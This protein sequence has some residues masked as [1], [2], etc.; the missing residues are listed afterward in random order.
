MQRL[1]SLA[2]RFGFDALIVVA[3]TESVIELIARHDAP[4]SPSSPTWFATAALLAL[5]LPLL[6]RRRFPFAV[7]TTVLIFATA[8]SFGDGRLMVFTNGAYA[9]GLAA[10]YLLGNQVSAGQAPIG[11]LVAA[12]GV[13]IVV[14]N[15][16]LHTAGELVVTPALYGIA[17]LAGFALRDRGARAVAAEERAARLEQQHELD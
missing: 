12:S 7:P 15:N 17:W 6:A 4:A 16:P 13:A 1:A 10:A 14:A 11:L 2:Q 8:V 5:I 3:A 9:A